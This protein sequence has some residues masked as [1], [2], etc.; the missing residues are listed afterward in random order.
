LAWPIWPFW[1][2]IENVDDAPEF[3]LAHALYDRTAHVEQ[4][5]EV[6]LMTSLHCSG[7]MRWN[8]VSRVMPALL[9]STSTGP[10]SARPA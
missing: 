10:R 9:T 7:F 5:I 6:V 2:L 3:S 1:P 8:M 4:R